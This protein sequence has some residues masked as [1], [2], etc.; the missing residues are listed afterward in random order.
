M[1]EGFGLEVGDL[2]AVVA[3]SLDEHLVKDCVG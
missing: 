2:S 1:F 3:D